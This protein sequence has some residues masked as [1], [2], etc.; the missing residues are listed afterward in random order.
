MLFCLGEPFSSMLKRLEKVDV[1]CVEVVDESKHALNSK[2]VR[3]LR[4]IAREK[5]LEFT[6]HAPFVDINI[7]SLNPELRQVMLKRL[8]KSM[9]HAYQLKSEMW[10]FHSGWK[11]GISEFYP[12]AD[13]Q[14]NLRSIRTLQATA[15]KLKEDISVENTPHPF[16]FLLKTMQ[17]FAL[18]YSELGGDLGL[19][20]DIAHAHTCNQA[21]DFI[22]KFSDKIVH[23][24]ASDN[25][26]KYDAHRGIGRG[27]IDWHAIAEGFKRINYKGYLMLE[28]TEHVED[29]LQKMRHIF[30]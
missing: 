3:S 9:R 10:V 4:K 29:S 27:N 22:E 23:V 30:V 2:R 15:R 5:G 26:G 16:P 19:T 8:E 12:E 20:L 24:H 7:A 1:D 17:D 11:T 14:L 13:W 18:F 25:N 28:S 21:L 6:V